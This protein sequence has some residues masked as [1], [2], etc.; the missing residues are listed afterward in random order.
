MN[1]IS[2]IT[3][4]LSVS[5]QTESGRKRSVSKSR[6]YTHSERIGETDSFANFTADSLKSAV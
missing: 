4:H 1:V 5:I 6:K 2:A 3:T